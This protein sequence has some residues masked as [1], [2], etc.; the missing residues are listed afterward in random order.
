MRWSSSAWEEFWCFL[1]KRKWR[2]LNYLKCDKC[3][4]EEMR[5][6][7]KCTNVRSILQNSITYIIH[8]STIILQFDMHQWVLNFNRSIKHI[9]FGLNYGAQGRKT[10]MSIRFTKWRDLYLIFILYILCCL[11]YI[12]S[13]YVFF[14]LKAD[15]TLFDKQTRVQTHHI[16]SSGNK[17]NNWW[18][19]WT[20]IWSV[21]WK[22]ME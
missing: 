9:M 1:Y 8:Y 10:V 19:W 13:Y 2:D 12:L 7:W 6:G 14:S 16:F 20:K 11:K 18:W 4:F 5:M 21:F 17:L 3:E 15:L 22:L